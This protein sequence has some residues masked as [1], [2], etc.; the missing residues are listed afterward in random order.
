MEFLGGRALNP[1]TD[2]HKTCATCKLDLPIESFRKRK[3]RNC[4]APYCKKCETETTVNAQNSTKTFCVNYK[5]GKCARCDTVFNLSQYAFHHTDPR[6]KDFSLSEHRSWSIPRL[7]NELD[8]CILVCH[9]CH[10]EI[11]HEIVK[12]EGSNCL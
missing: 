11:H 3:D 7:Q 4:L 6:E 12:K 10:A 1:E 5:G 2:T 9:N 8:K